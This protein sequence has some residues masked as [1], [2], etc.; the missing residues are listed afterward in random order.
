MLF[1]PMPARTC[2][3]I[4]VLLLLGLVSLQFHPNFLFPWVRVRSPLL[5]TNLTNNSC[6]CVSLVHLRIFFNVLRRFSLKIFLKILKNHLNF[7]ITSQLL[8]KKNHLSIMGLSLNYLCFFRY[9]I[10]VYHQKASYVDEGV[11]QWPYPFP[12]RNIQ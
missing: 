1:M 9:L 11:K 6:I 8:Y 12:Q 7:Q 2:L 5:W 4:Y 3:H 10:I